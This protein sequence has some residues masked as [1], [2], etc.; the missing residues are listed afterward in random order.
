M[1]W[2]YT[3]RKVTVI[4]P[5]H[6]ATLATAHLL[7]TMLYCYQNELTK[8]QPPALADRRNIFFVLQKG[9]VM[10]AHPIISEWAVVA[11]ATARKT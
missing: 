2:P 4:I 7:T 1:N 11:A 5:A 9:D 10:S 8:P 6:T 3:L